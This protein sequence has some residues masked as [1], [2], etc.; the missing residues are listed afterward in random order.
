ME[1]VALGLLPIVV[2]FALFQMISIRLKKRAVIKIIVGMV[3]TYSA[4]CCSSTGVN[5]GFMPAGYF[6]G[7]A[8]GSLPVYWLLVPIGM[9]VG[10]FIVAA[11][12]AVH[13][14]QQAG[15]GGYSGAIPQ[16]AIGL[17]L[18]IG[19]SRVH[20]PGHAAGCAWASP[21]TS[22]WCRAMPSP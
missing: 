9:V 11:E 17:A 16:R 5:V 6:L 1:E 2:F 22:C 20:R 8:L 4:W 19:V 3:Y 12:P 13:V 15:G 18:S 10:Y 21:S 7:G 14:A